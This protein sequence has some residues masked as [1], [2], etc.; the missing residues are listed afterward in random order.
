MDRK[1]PLTLQ[2][3]FLVQTSLCTF[4]MLSTGSRSERESRMLKMS[5]TM[6]INDVI[7]CP[8]QIKLMQLAWTVPPALA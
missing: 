1:Q 6:A 2:K 3:V 7:L 5:F 8:Y 4:F